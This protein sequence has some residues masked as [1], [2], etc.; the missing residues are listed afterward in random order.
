MTECQSAMIHSPTTDARPALKV[1]VVTPHPPERCESFVRAQVEHFGGSGHAIGGFP[2]WDTASGWIG[3]SL[4]YAH[5]AWSLPRYALHNRRHANGSDLEHFAPAYRRMLQRH[6]PDV[7]LAQYGTVGARVS[8]ACAQAGLPLVVHFHGF[9]AYKT[10]LL[11]DHSRAYRKMFEQAAA[12]VAVSKAMRAQ[13][14]KLGAREDDVHLIPYGVALDR[15]H[16]ERPRACDRRLLAVGRLVDKKAPHLTLRAF[17]TVCQR[18]PDATLDIIG[19]GPLREMCVDT[20]NQLGISDRVRFL[21][22]LGHDEVANAMRQASVFVQHSVVAEDGDQEGTPNA[23]LEAQASGLPVVSTH[24]AGIPDAVVDG[25]T[26]FLVDEG[27][28]EDM[29]SGI[30]RLLEDPAMARSMGQSGRRHIERNY[31]QRRQLDQLTDVLANSAL[32][33]NAV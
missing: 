7:V 33:R 9:D 10:R 16:C 24:H 28:V 19:D 20:A 21:G 22:S 8:A 13:L 32:Q 14:I 17:H 15:F 12:V 31:E 27:N 5:C 4:D 25:E 29:A 1:V 18:M 2:P 26:G 23:I 6:A 3:N 11:F 30:I